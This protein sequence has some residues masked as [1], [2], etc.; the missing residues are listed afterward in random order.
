MSSLYW[1]GV[2]QQC[3]RSSSS[4]EKS[5]SPTFNPYAFVIMVILINASR[6]KN[7]LMPHRTESY[8]SHTWP[9]KSCWCFKAFY[10]LQFLLY[11]WILI[12]CFWIGGVLY[13]QKTL[14][15]IWSSVACALRKVWQ[16][17]R[18]CCDIYSSDI[19][20]KLNYFGLHCK[21]KGL[22]FATINHSSIVVYYKMQLAFVSSCPYEFLVCFMLGISDPF[23]KMP[24][25]QFCCLK[26]Y[27][28]PLCR[29]TN[30]LTTV[31]RYVLKPQVKQ[32]EL[33]PE[34]SVLQSVDIV[35]VWE[36]FVEAKVA[37][38]SSRRGGKLC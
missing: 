30:T 13:S 12:V 37:S 3:I 15:L 16:C 35:S 33:Y 25:F 7:D 32:H 11:G 2:I 24:S 19:K 27:D 36:Q 28:R 14:F 17:C 21:D 5:M 9:D 4:K 20:S 29:A 26:N 38:T 10:F 8:T 23:S 22:T 6:E 18:S 34:Q 31:L 1:Y